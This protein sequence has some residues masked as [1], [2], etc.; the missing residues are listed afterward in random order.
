MTDLQTITALKAQDEMPVIIC[1]EK[2]AVMHVY[3]EKKMTNG[4]YR[5]LQ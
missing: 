4:K 5:R 3:A 1:D 2:G